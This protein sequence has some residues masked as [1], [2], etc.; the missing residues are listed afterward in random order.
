MGQ[1]ATRAFGWLNHDLAGLW[2]NLFRG[3]P[4]A[5]PVAYGHRALH[6]LGHDIGGWRRDDVRFSRRLYKFHNDFCARDRVRRGAWSDIPTDARPQ[7]SKESIDEHRSD[8][9]LPLGDCCKCD[10]IPAHAP[11]IRSGWFVV[12][13]RACFNHLVRGHAWMAMDGCRPFG[14]DF[15]FSPPVCLLSE[16][17]WGARMSWTLLLSCLWIVGAKLASMR[18]SDRKHWPLAYALMPLGAP[19][20][21]LAWWE[22][23]AGAA[24][25]VLAVGMVVLRWPVIYLGRRILRLL[26]GASDGAA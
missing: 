3:G 5:W 6:H 8:P 14:G 19:I 24:F 25:L 7:V 26:K 20:V 16:Q 15:T 12:M 17:V 13:R 10:G 9:L 22:H 2:R 4:V 23:G 11:A 21:A 1:F 18:P